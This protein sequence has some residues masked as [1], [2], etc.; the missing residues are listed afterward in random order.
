[1]SKSGKEYFCHI[2]VSSSGRSWRHSV[3]RQLW[4]H[5][6]GRGG[7]RS[8]S[9]SKL[10]PRHQQVTLNS[11][12][13]LW[14]RSRF[15]SFFTTRINLPHF[16][17]AKYIFGGILTVKCKYISCVLVCSG[18]SCW[19]CSSHVSLKPCISLRP[20]REKT[21]T[22]GSPSSAPQRTGDTHTHTNVDKFYCLC[23]ADKRFGEANYRPR[24]QLVLL[25]YLWIKAPFH[26]FS[27]EQ[28]LAG[29]PSQTALSKCIW[30]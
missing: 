13:T 3:H 27:P 29:V 12:L 21:S 19:S 17:L 1:M 25:F 2:S 4:V 10:R 20:P 30:F 15:S 22:P 7:L 8:D 11:W 23:K 16:F 9:A 14:C 26:V 28:R 18:R 5:L 24:T 6:G